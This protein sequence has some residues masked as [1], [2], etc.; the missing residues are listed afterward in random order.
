MNESMKNRIK[1]VRA[2]ETI[3]RNLNDEELIMDWLVVGV[4]DGDINESTTDEELEWYAEDDNFVELMTTFRK[5]MSIAT[6]ESKE[7][8]CFYCGGLVD[9]E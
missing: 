7:G 8:G 5:I 3:V 4:A 1:M 2:M 6:N 9:V